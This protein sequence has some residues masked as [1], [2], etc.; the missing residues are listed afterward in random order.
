MKF[1]KIKITFFV[2][3]LSA[4]LVS[5]AAMMPDM[6]TSQKSDLTYG[7]VK[8][9][10]KKGETNQA[11]VLQLLGGPNIITKDR[12]DLEVWTYEKVS[13]EA[14]EASGWSS[15]A[16]LGFGPTAAGGGAAGF[17]G[18]SSVSGSKTA[19]LI[20]KFDNKDVVKDYSMM[21]TKF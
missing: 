21:V 4:L 12:D 10:I 16:I 5:C 20:I 2:F 7:M 17:S 6:R 14:S 9:H 19:T 11:E 15:G 18:S 8:K 3:T 13:Y 1:Y